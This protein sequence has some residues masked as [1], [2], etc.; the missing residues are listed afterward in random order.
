MPTIE[1][2]ELSLLSIDDYQEL[3]EAMIDSYLNMPDSYWREQQ[4][5][6]LISLFP[7]GQAVIKINNQIAG[8]ALSIILD[9]DKYEDGHTYKEITG[10]YTF[11]T[12]NSNGDV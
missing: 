6:K 2:I 5:Q 7:E 8:C 1:N 3:K 10:E 12:H 4:I 9:Y 11:N